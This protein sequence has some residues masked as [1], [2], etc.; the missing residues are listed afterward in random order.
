MTPSLKEE[1]KVV[2]ILTKFLFCPNSGENVHSCQDASK[3]NHVISFLP[4]AKSSQMLEYYN[5]I[6]Q[7]NNFVS[8]T[9]EIFSNIL[10]YL[11]DKLCDGVTEIVAMDFGEIFLE[12]LI[13][14][15]DDIL[16]QKK[17]INLE[18]M[19]LLVIFH[20]CI[21]TQCDTIVR[22]TQPFHNSNSCIC[23][24]Q[25]FTVLISLVC[26]KHI[27][28][29]STLTIE[30]EIFFLQKGRCKSIKGIYIRGRFQW[31]SLILVIWEGTGNWK[32][33][34]FLAS[35]TSILS[36]VFNNFHMRIFL[37]Q[38]MVLVWW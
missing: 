10:K 20:C 28:R 29:L 7:V 2:T 3:L 36:D 24:Y 11:Q 25:T 30:S 31:I 15:W 23:W 8:S 17:F 9:R 35:V 4:L 33:P 16:G 37:H 34:Q 38:L 14:C 5:N 12:F 21:L 22:W 32:L 18:E 6:K 26:R 13:Y 19:H 27:H 1:I